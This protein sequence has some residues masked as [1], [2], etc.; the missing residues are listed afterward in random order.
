MFCNFEQNERQREI[1]SQT[2]PNGAVCR[3]IIKPLSKFILPK[4]IG[5]LSSCVIK[6][7][8]MRL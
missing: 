5:S 7:D 2:R 6:K 3:P 1:V 4:T 8:F